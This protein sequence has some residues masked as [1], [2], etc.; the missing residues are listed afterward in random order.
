MSAPE[1]R[2]RR[3]AL[4]ALAATLAIQVFTSLAATAP[5][6]LA[7]ELAGEMGFTP[8]WIGVFVGLVYAGAMLGSL[9]SPGFIDRFGAIRVSQICVLFCA[10]GI[11]SVGLLTA[12]VAGLLVAAAIVIGL[13]Y[14]PITPASSQILVKTTPPSQMAL[15][16]SIKQTGVPAGAALAGALLPV[17][18]LTVG[19]RAALVAVGVVGLAVIAAAQ[20]TRRAL[21]TDRAPGRAFS[22]RVIFSR[23]KLVAQSPPLAELALLSFAYAAV[24]VCL[25]S[26]LVVFLYGA[27]R[28]SL[29]AAGL[30]LTV[31]TVAG[32]VGRIAWGALADHVLAPRRVLSLIGLIAGL[33]SVTMAFAAPAWPLWIMLPVAALF[34]ATA[35]GWNG[36]Q[37][38][39]LA[40][41]APPGHAGAVTGASGF[42]TFAGVVVGPP[43]FAALAAL[44][45]G[46]RTGF[47]FLAVVS[48]VAAAALHFRSPAAAIPARRQGWK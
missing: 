1:E 7:P 35:I 19:W 43:L 42:I 11:T 15:I 33:C 32:V 44:T 14:G 31:A 30:A 21:D 45:D 47:L 41:R 27:L 22:P 8:R 2:S 38:S 13:G 9:S 24:Q 23:L 5:A 34:G 6:V 46:Y 26:F 4:V 28:W 20:S 10:V 25:T 36:V 17:A 16:F 39:E 29:V 12:S 18:A 3:R 40:R 48:I 37:L